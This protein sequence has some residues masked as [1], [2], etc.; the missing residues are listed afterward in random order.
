MKPILS[1]ILLACLSC[2]GAKPMYESD[3]VNMC[4]PMLVCAFSDDDNGHGW[5][6]CQN[7]DGTCPNP[8]VDGG[9]EYPQ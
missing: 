1:I 9:Q 4:K 5:C 6:L 2:G 3:C 7:I 8:G